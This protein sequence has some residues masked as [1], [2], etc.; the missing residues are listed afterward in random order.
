LPKFNIGKTA[1]IHTKKISKSDTHGVKINTQEEHVKVV[2]F[3]LSFLV[4]FF[5]FH[6][7]LDML[8]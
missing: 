4:V 8:K 1:A 7:M 6:Y 2:T 5:V 3:N